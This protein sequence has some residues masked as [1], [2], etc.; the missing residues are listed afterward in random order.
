MKTQFRLAVTLLA[1]ILCAF[2]VT[3]TGLWSIQ[4]RIGPYSLHHWFSIIGGGYILGF[5]AV[6]A[7]VKGRPG[8]RRGSLLT[9]HV[10]GNLLALVLISIHFA[11]HLSRHAHSAVELGTGLTAFILLTVAVAAGFMMRFGLAPEHRNTWRVIHVGVGLS[12]FV[13]IG[14]HAL[15]NFGFL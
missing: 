1:V 14:I 5:V 9:A 8:V 6:Y 4:A 7:A 12:L 13:V 10:F 11:Q 15:H 2:V 3:Y